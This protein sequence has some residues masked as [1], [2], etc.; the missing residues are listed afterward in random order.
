M[1]LKTN[2][3]LRRKRNRKFACSKCEK[4]FTASTKLVSHCVKDHKME[5]KNIK[6]FACERLSSL[7]LVRGNLF[8]FL[9]VSAALKSSRLLQTCGNMWSITMEW[10][11]A[12]ACIVERALLRKPICWIMKKS[13]LIWGNTN[14]N[15]VGK[16]SILTKTLGTY[17]FK[18]QII[19]FM[20]INERKLNTLKM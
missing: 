14:V 9:C 18:H 7:A 4:S 15:R 12:S 8:S 19:H 3:I 20:R 6:P 17:L 10:N 2:R 16:A 11:P 1:G 13:I 5:S